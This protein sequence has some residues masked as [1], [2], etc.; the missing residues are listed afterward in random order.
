ME[1]KNNKEELPLQY[2]TD[3]FGLIDPEQR[4][5]E[6]EI[7][8]ADD[9]FSLTFLGKRYQIHWPD[10]DVNSDEEDAWAA[11]SNQARIFLLRYLLNGQPFPANGKYLSFRE[12]PSGEVYIRPFTGR[13]LT[14]SAWKYNGDPAGFCA[15]AEALGGVPVDHA[16][17][18]Y[19][20]DL[21]G[22]YHLL[23]YLWAG[24]DEFPPNAQVEFS[25][26]FAVGFTA[27]DSVVAA[28]M[29]IS[30]IS[31]RMKRG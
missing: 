16:D 15:A 6:L 26:N 10:G 23:F 30:A 11:G 27:E 13:C 2:Y 24:D 17:A 31:A 29:I 18:G 19:R 28:E 12:L 14:R 7:P 4:A 8:Y 3:R 25:N 22:D 9:C 20:F 5:K 1:V 21:I